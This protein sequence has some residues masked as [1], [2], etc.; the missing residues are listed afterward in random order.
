MIE[1]AMIFALGFLI[2]GLLAV[3][4]APA[5][6]H[7][8]IRLSTRRLEMQ[9]PLSPRE[10][11][12][13]RDLLRAEFAIERRRLEQK[14]EALSLIHFDDMEELGRRAAVI[15]ESEA[16]LA[17]LRRGLSERQAEA[18]EAKRALTQTAAEFA[19]ASSALEG[20]SI[21]V[22]RKDAELIDVRRDLA[23][24]QGSVSK[25]SAAL[26]DVEAQ[27]A[28]L[29]E[30]LSTEREEAAR[31]ADELASAR[32]EHA[33]A[34]A[35]LKA[36]AGTVVSHEAAL[37]D[38]ARRE[39]E[40]QERRRRGIETARAKE[41]RLL[42]RLESLS[43]S[44]AKA[45]AELD[46]AR[47]MADAHLGDGARSSSVDSPDGEAPSASAG[48]DAVQGPPGQ[49][50]SEF[51]E[52]NAV[53]RQTINEIGAAIIRMAASSLDQTHEHFPAKDKEGDQRSQRP[54]GR[55]LAKASG[56]E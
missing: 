6:W 41:R 28:H 18:E 35:S 29:K 46:R 53:L 31:L 54:T 43:A 13:D 2:A 39:A 21:L 44:E 11:L 27:V 37:E 23:I 14:A 38:A 17:V 19:A 48:R 34:L 33:A 12:A 50:A 49:R 30:K 1:Q 56:A 45:W 25:L 3:A 7:R 22:E 32:L 15:V 47:A 24:A 8:A 26:V 16:D 51:D 5:F 55:L 42:A 52:E 20:A 9:I 36:T 4:I 10:I 40:L